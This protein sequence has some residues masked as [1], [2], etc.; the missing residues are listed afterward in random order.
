M[1]K[2]VK[3]RVKFL[4]GHVKVIIFVAKDI[5]AIIK[6]T[7]KAD[8]AM[9]KAV[10]AN[11]KAIKAMVKAIKVMVYVVNVTLTKTNSLCTTSPLAKSALAN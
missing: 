5:K 9:V 11:V 8:M 2:V 4:Q 10:K 1:V 7:I 6:I 3:V